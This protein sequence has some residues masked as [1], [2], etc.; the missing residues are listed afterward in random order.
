MK[1]K[2]IGTIAVVMGLFI[3]RI[4]LSSAEIHGIHGED[5]ERAIR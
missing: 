3:P 1:K 4:A 2:T 5:E